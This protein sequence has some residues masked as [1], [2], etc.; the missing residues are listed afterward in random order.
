MA[1][2][3]KFLGGKWLKSEDLGGIGKSTIVTIADVTEGEVQDEKKGTKRGWVLAFVG[4]DKALFCN[5]T[6]TNQMID[7][8]GDDTDAWF[9][10]HI[11]LICVRVDFA[12]KK[13]PAIRIEPAPVVPKRG[14]VAAPPPP[15]EP[16]ETEE[17]EIT[18]LTAD[19]IP[20]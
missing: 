4:K 3:R 8:F 12:G 7:L 17:E 10:K 14:R 18:E 9:D 11:K 5:T 2:A 16:D 19:D 6:N 1:D 20:F 13:V 15:P